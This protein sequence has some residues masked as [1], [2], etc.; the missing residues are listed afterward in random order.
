MLMSIAVPPDEKF[1]ESNLHSLKLD[2]SRLLPAKDQHDADVPW[3][4]PAMVDVVI[5]QLL[6]DSN[7]T[8]TA[9]SATTTFGPFKATNL[10]AA[11]DTI[12]DAVTRIGMLEKATHPPDALHVALT[13]KKARPLFL[14]RVSPPENEMTRPAGTAVDRSLFSTRSVEATVS[15][16]F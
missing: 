8:A 3:P 11:K 12:E 2:T 16:T 15:S 10:H 6:P 5:V 1:D 13:R 7:C 4:D 9:L 14:L